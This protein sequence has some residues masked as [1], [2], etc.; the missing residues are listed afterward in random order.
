V[1]TSDSLSDV[2]NYYGAY[3]QDDF[4]ITSKLTLNLESAMNTRLAFTRRLTRWSSALIPRNQ[5]D[6]EPD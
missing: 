2:I 4:R 1:A 3:L 5:S 6:P